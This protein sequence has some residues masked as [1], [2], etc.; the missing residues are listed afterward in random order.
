MQQYRHTLA[1]RAAR[2]R[3][4][5]Q[6]AAQV[7]GE[8]DVPLPKRLCTAHVGPPRI[9][10]GCP[11][12]TLTDCNVYPQ[13]MPSSFDQV[14]PTKH[15]CKQNASARIECVDCVEDCPNMQFKTSDKCPECE[16]RKT[17][18]PCRGFGLFAPEKGVS[19]DKFIGEYTGKVLRISKL[20]N[21]KKQVYIMKIDET[22]CLDA[23]ECGNHT[24]FINHSCMPNCEVQKWYVRG[25]PCVGIFTLR[26]I[27][28]GEELTFDYGIKFDDAKAFACKCAK[29]YPPATVVTGT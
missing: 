13:K 25:L 1:P 27:Q 11:L 26:D 5:D 18:E 16:V 20:S 29:C 2:V 8:T 19:K 3:A 14:H 21:L 6:I 22:W 4:M 15:A 10:P 17:E 28:P 23:L 24:R 7:A 12:F 9:P